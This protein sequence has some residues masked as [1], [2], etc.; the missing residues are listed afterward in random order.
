MPPAVGASAARCLVRQSAAPCSL[1]E[2]VWRGDG[3]IA[4]FQHLR[5]RRDAGNGVLAELADAVGERTQ[6]P[7]ADVDRAAAHAGHHAGVLRLG[8]VELRQD[9]V[10]A[11]AARAAQHTQ[12]L[13]LH[14]LRFGPFKYRPG[15]RHHAA[16]HLAERERIRRSRRRAIG[17]RRALRRQPTGQSKAA[18]MPGRDC[19]GASRRSVSRISFTEFS[20]L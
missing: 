4:H 2:A 19:H 9:H 13:N 10:L 12:N 18:A 16:A 7:V 20:R 11:G 8:A 17:S 6:Q 1:C 14:R 5:D 3:Q 15:G